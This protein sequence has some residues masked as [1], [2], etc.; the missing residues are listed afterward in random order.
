M[1]LRDRKIPFNDRQAFINLKALFEDAFTEFYPARSCAEAARLLKDL[2]IGIGGTGCF[3]SKEDIL[4]EY[5]E[6]KDPLYNGMVQYYADTMFMFRL[7]K[8]G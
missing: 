1:I 4:Y 2:L 3:V 5:Y 6:K 7:F 8:C